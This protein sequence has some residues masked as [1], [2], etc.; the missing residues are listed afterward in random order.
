MGI[1]QND[2]FGGKPHAGLVFDS[3]ENII[4]GIVILEEFTQSTFVDKYISSVDLAN[5]RMQT[6]KMKLI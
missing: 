6:L 5:M 4:I 3:K 2:K 1:Y